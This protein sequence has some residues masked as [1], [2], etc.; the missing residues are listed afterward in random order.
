MAKVR[1]Q[2][3]PISNPLRELADE[4]RKLGKSPTAQA[5]RKLA[6]DL[7]KSPKLPAWLATTDSDKL[8]KLVEQWNQR[9]QEGQKQAEE[10]TKSRKLLIDDANSGRALAREIARELNKSNAGSTGPAAANLTTEPVTTKAWATAEVTKM[11]RNKEISDDIGRNSLAKL[12]EERNHT[13]AE[14]NKL[15]HRVGWKHLANELSNWGLWPVTAVK[16]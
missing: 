9:W 12:L 2:R 3:T 4:L 13:A 1:W 7:K 11:K 16:I 10:A 14:K 8:E 15:L 6:A 5:L